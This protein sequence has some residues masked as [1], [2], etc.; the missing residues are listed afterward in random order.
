MSSAG[1]LGRFLRSEE[2]AY[3]GHRF[4][5][6][7]PQFFLRGMW[8]EVDAQHVGG[9]GCLHHLYAARGHTLLANLPET[10]LRDVLCITLGFQAYLQ[11]QTKTW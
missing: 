10:F 4:F 3:V 9:S 6:C 8:G 7:A 11:K 2:G 1:K 5:L